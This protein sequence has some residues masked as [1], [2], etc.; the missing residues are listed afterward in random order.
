[1]PKRPASYLLNILVFMTLLQNIVTSSPHSNHLIS[2]S[3]FC[4]ISGAQL[5]DPS[6]HSSTWSA[7]YME[8][9]ER[10][11][12]FVLLMETQFPFKATL[13]ESAGCVSLP[14]ATE[15]FQISVHDMRIVIE[16][17]DLKSKDEL[18]FQHDSL[19]EKTWIA[20][21][22][23]GRFHSYVGDRILARP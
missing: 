15:N 14:F 19:V 4:R 1:M 6:V 7:I 22:N 8:D 23:I 13:D 12:L 20:S 18:V 3:P 16:Y 9:V 11:I 10:P 17:S 2:L 5:L 21:C